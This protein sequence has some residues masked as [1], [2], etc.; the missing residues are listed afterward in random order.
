MKSTKQQKAKMISGRA[1]NA[2]LLLLLLGASLAFPT[3]T[4]AQVQATGSISGTVLDPNSAALSGVQITVTN[5]ATGLTREATTDDEGRYRIPVLPTGTYQVK[6]TQ[7]GFSTAQVDNVIVEAAV[8]RTVDQALQVG[9]VGETVNILESGALITPETATT[10]RSINAEEIV[11][12]PTST[13]LFFNG[14]DATNITS[15]EG[16]L[17]DN[18]APAPETLEEVKLQTSLYD[19]STGRSGGGNFQLISRS[20]TNSFHG[21]A[22]YFLQNEKLNAND[23]FFNRDGIERPRARR[24]E[25]GFTV[26][27][28]IIPDRFFFFGGY[29]R[30]QASTGLVPT[31][32]SQ[33]TLPRALGRINGART[34]ENIVAAFRAD[35]PAF[36]LTP[37]QVS[38]LA[39]QL[40]NTINPVTGDFIVPSPRSNA[41]SVGVDQSVALTLPGL[42][43]NIGG[44]NP[45]VRQR[46][47]FPAEF[48]QDQ[49]TI[50]LDGQLTTNNRLSGTFF[51]ANFPGFDPFTEPNAQ[52]SPFQLRRDD[53]NRTLAISDTHIFGASL[54]NEA[55]FGYFSLNNT[56]RLDDPFL[57]PE[58]TGEAFGIVNPALRF[59]DSPGTRRLGH[60]VGRNNISGFAFGGPNDSFNQRDQKTFSFSDNV[61]FTTGAHTFRFGGEYKRQAYDT[62]LP[63]EQA[64]EFEKFD[65]FTQF[66][67]G[68]ATEADTQFG[69]TQKEFRFSDAS[70]YIADDFKV[71]P[72]LTLNLGLRYEFYGLPTERNG[73]IGNFDPSLITSTENPLAGFIIPSNVQSTGFKAVDDAIAAT[74]KV[75]NKHTLNGQ[76]TNNF[77][78][79]FG[80]A[81]S[82]GRFNNKVVLRGGYGIFY[83]RPSTAFINTIFSNYPFL[84]EIEVTA[85]APNIP[86]Q[87]A[88]STQVPLTDLGL[89]NFLPA[90]IVYEG[91]GTFRIRDN[92]GVRV[93]PVI[94]SNGQ[95]TLN[96][97]DLAT[98]QPILGNIAETFEFRAI[99]RDL[100]TPYIQQYNLG[101]QYEFA[102]DTL[103]EVRYVGTK[104]T[105]L[106]QAVALNQGY[107]FNDPN[108]PDYVYGRFTQAYETAYNG[109]R[110]RLAAGQ[111]TQAQ[112]NTAFPNGALRPGATARER[113]TGVAFGFNNVLTGN[114]RDLNLTTNSTV[115]AAGVISGGTIL[116]FEARTP[117]L[118]FNVPEALFLRSDG[119]S[120]YNALQINFARRLSRGLQFNTSYTFSKS[121]DTSS[122]DPGSTAGGG[123]PDVPNAG[124][125]VQGNS[126]DPGN[127]RALSD[128]DRTH[129]VSA[130]F[131]YNIPTFGNTSRLLSGFQLAGFVQA[132]SGTP[133]TIFSPEPEAGNV[134]ALATLRNGAGGIFRLGFGRP[135]L[136]GT[137]EE[138]RQGGNGVDEAYFNSSVLASP[139]GGFGTLGRNVLRGPTQKRFDLSLSK[140]TRITEG[141]SFEIRADAFNI[142]NNVNFANPSG[143]I[144][145]STD[146]G[147]TTNTIGGP[148]VVQFG[149]KFRF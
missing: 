98:G 21:S 141:T 65:N 117:I 76:D 104:G 93:T 43:G 84:R 74:T 133:F 116:G 30:T 94:G 19:A 107:D 39:L 149:A 28:P 103:I 29:Q 67:L 88:F 82:P 125:I 109:A 15:N 112:F 55:R 81:Y 59:D 45:L 85:G 54:I 72:S 126:Y 36:P 6:F 106:L 147:F 25:G 53:S 78:P 131:V 12:V 119:T 23:F 139:L 49:F 69:T 20:G 11:Q 62:N 105:K 41:R 130:S 118:G 2:L 73:R 58:L 91:A 136:V 102:R 101:V 32:S 37:A 80:F 57:T 13:S 61:T 108:T 123:R 10:A 122:V 64:T 26:G 22:Y 129:R 48:E 8:P 31:A 75:N 92:T 3:D 56:R 97:T 132:Q 40:L 134:A 79:R 47:V 113:G 68:R 148:R 7:T 16:S 83:D 128:F 44:G 87:S 52:A 146:F 100:R 33:T 144:S 27:G 89:N 111:L 96:P 4:W 143:D 124:F 137:L 51:F 34:A 42:T 77:A 99:D 5:P 24:N 145:D 138:L 63:E 60:F 18:I 95:N 86:I 110:T 71:T 35:N 14:I 50:K 70:G 66:L 140:T 90:R 114:T 115:N 9:T 38:P 142:F 17:N 1:V 46:N 120:N 121:I 127:N 135:N